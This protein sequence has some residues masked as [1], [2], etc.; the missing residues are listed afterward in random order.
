[1]VAKQHQRGCSVTEDGASNMEQHVTYVQHFERFA[2]VF[3]TAI[4]TI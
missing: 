4:V 1:M 2:D 3:T